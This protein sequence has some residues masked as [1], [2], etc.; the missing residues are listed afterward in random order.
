LVLDADDPAVATKWIAERAETGDH[1]PDTMRVLTSKAG[2]SDKFH[3][4]LQMPACHV[5]STVKGKKSPIPGFD[6]RANGW[7]CDRAAIKT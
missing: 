4:Y 3:L 6:I 1:L 5:P 7:L 2:G